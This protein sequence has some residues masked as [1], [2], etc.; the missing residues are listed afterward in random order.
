VGLV[1]NGLSLVVF[2]R[3]KRTGDPTVQY[4]TLVTLGDAGVLLFNA[5]PEWLRHSMPYVVGTTYIDLYGISS[6]TCKFI[7]FMFYFC[8]T[9]SSFCLVCFSLERAVFV[10]FPL[11]RNLFSSRNRKLALLVVCLLSIA[12]NVHV[13]I[14]M[15]NYQDAAGSNCFYK[16]VVVNYITERLRYVLLPCVFIFLFN[17][18]IIIGL[19]KSQKERKR[20]VAADTLVDSKQ[21]VVLIN[22]IL[23]SV[24]FLAFNLPR[25]V[26][27][28]VFEEAKK[29][30]FSNSYL[31][32]LFLT[33]KLCAVLWYL[34]Y[35]TN[36]IIYC[37][38]LTFYREELTKLVP[39][40]SKVMRH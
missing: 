21:K 20:M 1:G 9:L 19:I 16:Y 34:N 40:S 37:L 13:A 17:V 10:W 33:A 14:F 27:W 38:S 26:V 3:T 35:S 12:A 6:F 11:K 25:A 32:L 31:Q 30:G 7:R 4:F 29:L 23:V 36:F 24:F 8:A 2:L 39:F 22:L 5:L 15:E 18:V 28:S